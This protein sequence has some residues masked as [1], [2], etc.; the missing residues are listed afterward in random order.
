MK[1]FKYFFALFFIIVH[2]QVRSAQ[3]SE[4]IL[5]RLASD[6]QPDA[7]SKAIK[8]GVPVDICNLYQDTAL[9]LAAAKGNIPVVEVLLQNGADVH[10]QNSYGDTALFHAVR[11]R[12]L[13]TCLMLLDARA[14]INHRN[15][16]QETAL[17]NAVV[18]RDKTMVVELLSRGAVCNNIEDRSGATPFFK[19]V[20]NGDFDIANEFLMRKVDINYVNYYQ[21]TLLM[22][23]T[24][25]LGEMF[26]APQY[27][28]KILKYLLYYEKF[29]CKYQDKRILQECVARLEEDKSVGF[30]NLIGHMG[31]KSER[32]ELKIKETEYEL[33]LALA[34]E[35][36]SQKNQI[37]AKRDWLSKFKRNFNAY[38]NK[39]ENS[40]ADCI[41]DAQYE[42][43][44]VELLRP[45]DMNEKL[46]ND[47]AQT[48]EQQKRAKIL[49][50]LS[51]NSLS[52]S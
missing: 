25:H 10:H 33:A 43:I 4:L 44:V 35:F 26:Y 9:Y 39:E 2:G 19:A 24:K 7:V 3:Q 23:L 18:S 13:R 38:I 42:S 34:S 28:I 16:F 12:S 15:N 27:G 6:N 14:D 31:I 46:L 51:N 48:V 29:L 45:T 37:M 8:S 5:F 1:Y 20:A 40:L 30:Y 41:F 36:N 21:E 49:M 52:K 32:L 11:S 47:L 22:Y 17:F 50:R